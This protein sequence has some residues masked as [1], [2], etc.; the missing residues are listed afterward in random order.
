MRIS[1]YLPFLEVNE[2]LPEATSS[3]DHAHV[4]GSQEGKV[5]SDNILSKRHNKY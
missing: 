4:D 2:D 3:T 1:G 5:D